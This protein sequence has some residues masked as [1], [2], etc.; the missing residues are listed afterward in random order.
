[1]FTLLI[2]GPKQPENDIDAY[3]APLIEDLSILWTI[4][5]QTFDAFLEESFTLRAV[6]LWTINDFPTYSNLA[7]C[8]MKGYCACPICGEDTYAKRLKFS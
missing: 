4:G 5:V 1:M 6:L 2:A 8:K 7:G 3:L